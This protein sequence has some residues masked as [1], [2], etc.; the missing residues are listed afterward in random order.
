MKKVLLAALMTATTATTFATDN[1]P[2]SNQTL[3]QL[4]T[5]VHRYYNIYLDV[6][7]DPAS[8]AAMKDAASLKADLCLT[9]M[10]SGDKEQMASLL[11]TITNDRM[12]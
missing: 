12:Q 9:A 1:T 6:A 3:Q 8:D 7:K 4:Y 10:T 5:N 2:V 11:S